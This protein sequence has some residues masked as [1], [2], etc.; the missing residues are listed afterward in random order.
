VNIFQC[1][2]CLVEEIELWSRELG[3]EIF[4]GCELRERSLEG[5]DKQTSF[6]KQNEMRRNISADAPSGTLNTSE[7][8]YNSFGF[9]DVSEQKTEGDYPLR[10]SKS[11]PWGSGTTLEHDGT[12]GYC[13]FMQK[14]QL[15]FEKKN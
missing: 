6:V 3:E 14:I 10:R 2:L 5:V 13:N 15:F 11:F 8:L 7:I 9:V 12:I 1:Q 4:S